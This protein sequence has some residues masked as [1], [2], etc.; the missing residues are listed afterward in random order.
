VYFLEASIEDKVIKYAKSRGALVLK[1]NLMGNTGWPDRLFLFKGAHVYL[2]FKRPGEVLKRNQPDRVHRLVLNGATV[3]IFDDV[4]TSRYFLDATIFSD[5]WRGALSETGMCWIALQ[6]WTW[7]DICNVY[8]LSD[9][10]GQGLC[11]EVPSNLSATA[12]IRR[13]ATSKR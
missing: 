7:K 11:T 10:A 4:T 12:F 5:G 13:V 9:L 3:G 8:G 6:A 2:E 1:L